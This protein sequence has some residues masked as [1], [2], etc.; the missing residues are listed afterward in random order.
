M[1]GVLWSIGRGLRLLVFGKLRALG[2]GNTAFL[3]QAGL[4][5]MRIVRCIMIYRNEVVKGWA[6]GII[7]SWRGGDFPWDRTKANFPVF[8]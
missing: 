4:N 1:R 5:V 2:R 8:Y 6:P 3:L 7:Y